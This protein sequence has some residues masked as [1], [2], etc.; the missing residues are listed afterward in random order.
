MTLAMIPLVLGLLLAAALP[1][2]AQPVQITLMHLSDT[3][4]HLA[5][6]GPKDANLDGTLGGLPKVA[7]IVAAERIS[8]PNTL[9][10][11]A[12]DVM[13]GDF[14]FNEY[15]G[16]DEFLLLREIGLDAFVPGNHEW[17]FGPGF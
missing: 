14:F 17:R 7:A 12:G 15:L 1:A 2:T 16:V 10:V 6:W 13:D 11:H 3:H 9:F 4:S 5:A 8:D